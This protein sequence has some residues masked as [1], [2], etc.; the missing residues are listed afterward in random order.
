MYI[1]STKLCAFQA[2]AARIHSCLFLINYPCNSHQR[3]LISWVS[4]MQM[5]L[6]WAFM[7]IHSSFINEVFTTAILRGC[8]RR[9]WRCSLWQAHRGSFGYLCLMVTCA[10]EQG[11]SWLLQLLPQIAELTTYLLPPIVDESSIYSVF[12]LFDGQGQEKA[13]SLALNFQAR[14]RGVLELRLVAGR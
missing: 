3:L 7:I 9:N 14:H 10:W 6:I 13:V 5:M 1:L 2:I 12:V 11:H 4:L 8:W